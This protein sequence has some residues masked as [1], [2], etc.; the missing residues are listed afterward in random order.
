MWQKSRRAP[1]IAAAA[2]VL[3]FTATCVASASRST[4]QQQSDSSTLIVGVPDDA[5]NIDPVFAADPRSTEIIMNS[6]DTLT[7]YDLKTL[8]SGIKVFDPKKVSGLALSKLKV[9]PNGKT[10]TLTVRKGMKFPDGTPVDAKALQ[11]MFARNFGIKSGGGGFMYSY[12]GKIPGI[13]SV[14]VTGPDTLTVTTTAPNPIVSDMFALSN[15]TPLD[16]A[17]L[18]KNGGSDSYAQTWLARNT[19]GS[20]PYQLTKWVPGSEIDLT[21]NPNYWRGE[22]S[23]RNVVERIIPSAANR[24]L[25]LERGVI[26]MAEN[27]SPDELQTLKKANGVKVLSIPSSNGLQ[28]IMDVNTAPFTNVNVRRAIEY[29]VPYQQIIDRV[30]H[31]MARPTAGP[32]P[33]GFPDHSSAGYPYGK[34]NIAK[35]KALLAAANVSQGTKLTLKINSGNPTD[36]A[37]AVQIQAA[38]KQVGLDVQIQQL[39]PAVYAQQ[40]QKGQLGFFLNESQWWVPD[41]AYSTG[42]GYTCKA[43][44]NYG[45]YC[46]KQV[47]T[48]IAAATTQTNPTKRAAMFAAVQKQIEA[49]APMVWIA[50]PNDTVAMRDNVS[51]Y[52]DFNDGMIRFF[53]LKKS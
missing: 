10:W 19:A 18:S 3:A 4:T 46:N 47:D 5:A 45:H 32:I 42:L 23:I 40:R 30:Y 2:A 12:V 22:P 31:G 44:F 17:L 35:A 6:Y 48:M 39:T 9:S 36:Q 8:P 26:D 25:F 21:A 7:T 27:L 41:P 34:Q 1:L 20:G 43:F 49:D 13:N 11:F 38:L 50:Q 28:L 52:A 37:N 16:E 33:I 24:V 51:G 14:K 53:Y 29:A 15:S